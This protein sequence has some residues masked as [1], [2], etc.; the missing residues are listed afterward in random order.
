MN[1]TTPIIGLN[2]DTF[3]EKNGD[4]TGVR[5]VY[6]EAVERAGGIPLLIPHLTD[7]Q[8][9]QRIL[10]LVDGVLLVGGDD[11]SPERLAQAC[12]APVVASPSSTLMPELREKSDFLLIELLLELGGLRPAASVAR[13]LPVLGIC[14]ANQEVA[15][16][17][18]GSL[19]QHLP[20]D[21]PGVMHVFDS[22][23]G[24]AARHAVRVAPGSLL[25]RIWGGAAEM[26]V[27]SAHHQGVKS[28]GSG[29]R[30]VAWAPDGLIEALE[31]LDHPFFLTVQWHP[32]R[33][34]DEPMQRKLF[35]ALVHA[36]ANPVC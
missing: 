16:V 6:W 28:A 8:A 35:S 19:H 14:L 20:E 12:G 23:H 36:A 5:Q 21:L 29:P 18:G 17:H 2:C 7:R 1:S 25:A 22:P 24:Q 31:L 30:A 10:A 3:R 34:P 13:T 4:I 27:N 32:E 9:L 11:I 15:V 26:G 33:L